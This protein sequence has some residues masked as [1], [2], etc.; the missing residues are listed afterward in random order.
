MRKIRIAIMLIGTLFAVGCATPSVSQ[1]RVK[2]IPPNVPWQP[3]PSVEF[4]AT[5]L[6]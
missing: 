5:V 3:Y 2:V 1:I 4:N 6:K